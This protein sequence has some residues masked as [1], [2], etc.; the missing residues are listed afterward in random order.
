MLT[1]P[2]RGQ[3]AGSTADDEQELKFADPLPEKMLNDRVKAE[4]VYNF[5]SW[6]DPFPSTLRIQWCSLRSPWVPFSRILERN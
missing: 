5:D 1:S 4:S 3:I 2:F 6:E